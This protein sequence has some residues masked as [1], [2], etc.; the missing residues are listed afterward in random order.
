MNPKVDGQLQSEWGW[1]IAVYLFLGGIGGGA[2]TIA[3]A[4]W[5]LGENQRGQA[6]Y[7]FTSGGCH[8]AITAA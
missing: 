6:H 2:Y 3:A 5:F 4:N 8:D 7:D 1:W